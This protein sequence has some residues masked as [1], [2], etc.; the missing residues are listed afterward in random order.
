MTKKYPFPAGLEPNC[1]YSVSVRGTKGGGSA[2]L[3][4]NLINN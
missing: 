3:Q 2:L 4:K 1:E